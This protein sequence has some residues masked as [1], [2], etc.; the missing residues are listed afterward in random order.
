MASFNSRVD[1]YIAQSKDYAQPIL[2][3]LRN[4]V[5]QAC[6]LVEETIK[7]RMPVFEYMGPLCNMAAFNKHCSFGF[8]KAALMKDPALML[9]AKSEVAMGHLGK[10]YS[11]KDIPSNTKM[12]AYIK[13]AMTLN[14]MGM[15]VSKKK[16]PALPPII[17]PPDLLNALKKQKEAMITFSA[18]SNSQ[19]KEYISW[20]IEAKTELT[21][22]KR[23]AQSVEWMA[24]GKER[25]WKYK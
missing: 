15:K 7:W 19:K 21:R 25:N 8:W 3:H 1:D 9:T 18:F 12:I 4:L 23:I 20:I 22:N 24:E 5:H 10:I 11:V 14:E 16:A 17:A 13:E 6:P 2:E